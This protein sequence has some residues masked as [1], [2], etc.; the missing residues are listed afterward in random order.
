MPDGG[1]IGFITKEINDQFLE[2][3]KK[4]LNDNIYKFSQ[5]VDMGDEKFS[6]GAESGESRKWKLLSLENKSIIKERKFTRALQEQFKIISSS[7]KKKNIDIPYTDITYTF[8]RNI[9]IDMLYY[10]DIIQ[11]LKGLISDETLFANIPFINDP[12]LEIEKMK[13]DLGYIPIPDEVVEDEEV[14]TED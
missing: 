10:A 14:E 12:Q 1:D 8:T 4:T 9:P 3:H 7:W 13:P 11:K 2:N 6:G 5:T